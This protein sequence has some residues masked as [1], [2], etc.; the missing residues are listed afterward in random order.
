MSKI[1]QSGTQV[2]NN[3]LNTLS[4]YGNPLSGTAN[5]LDPCEDVSELNKSNGSILV[6]NSSTDKYELT[7]DSQDGGSF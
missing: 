2:L 1:F 6:Y 5:R 3:T 4:I 7:E